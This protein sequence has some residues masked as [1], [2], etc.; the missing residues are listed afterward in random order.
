MRL[1][2]F[3]ASAGL[4]SRRGV[5]E[6]I[7]AGRVKINGHVVTDLA[8]Q[9]SPE[10]SVKVGSRVVHSEQ[11]IAAVL[12]KPRGYLCTASDELE[13]RTI[14]E[15]LPKRWPRVFHVGRLDKESEGLL[16]VTNDGDL[17][18]ALT[19]PS[20]EVD[21]EYEVGLDRPFDSGHR[22]K[23]L[24]G[25]RI[26]GGLAKA[27]QINV[28]TPQLLKVVLRQGIKREIRLMFYSLGYEVTHLRRIR[29]GSLRIGPL[30]PG[31]WRLLTAR[32]VQE[33]KASEPKPRPARPQK[34]KAAPTGAKSRVPA[35]SP[36]LRRR[37]PKQ[38]RTARESD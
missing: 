36:S 3:L 26:E 1:N 8:A 38:R 14:F 4:G 35:K 30:K 5:E 2:R 33:L 9:V 16:I 23:L 18:M 28:V 24:K 17:S 34:P 6:I 13:R 37:P 25:I 12:N 21:K 31:E 29:I 7:I 32:E 11:P 15:L 19:H 10:D 20:H 22:E 27:Y